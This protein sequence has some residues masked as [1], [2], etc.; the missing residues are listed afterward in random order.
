PYRGDD[1]KATLAKVLEGRLE[2]PSGARSRDRAGLAVICG[3]GL[4]KDP[5]D[6]YPS[7]A[8]LAEDLDRWL[9]GLP[10]KA[11]PPGPLVRMGRLVRRRSFLAASLA[12]C[13]LGAAALA[14]WQFSRPDPDA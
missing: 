10:T 6:R 1:R 3:K 7:A 13:G 4:E 11:K 8:A 2:P 5:R 9:D 14:G 12:A